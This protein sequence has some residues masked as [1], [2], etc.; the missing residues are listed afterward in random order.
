MVEDYGAI[1]LQSLAILEYH[2]KH[3][4]PNEQHQRHKNLICGSHTRPTTRVQEEEVVLYS[5]DIER[6]RKT[7]T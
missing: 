3:K 1:D 4:S 5:N 6:H 7:G 2:T